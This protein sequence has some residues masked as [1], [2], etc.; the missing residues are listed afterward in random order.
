MRIS[1][2]RISANSGQIIIFRLKYSWKSG[3]P[4]DATPSP[5][6]PLPLPS[7]AQVLFLISRM[8][9]AGLGLTAVRVTR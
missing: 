4:L 7:P 8:L 3:K 1:L 5:P 2:S 6:P 9:Q